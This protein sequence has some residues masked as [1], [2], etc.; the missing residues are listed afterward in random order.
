MPAFRQFA[1]NMSVGNDTDASL[2]H[3]GSLG[4]TIDPVGSPVG[5]G[6]IEF[7]SFAPAPS[8]AAS[9]GMPYYRLAYTG[10]AHTSAPASPARSLPASPSAERPARGRRFSNV[11]QLAD[12]SQFDLMD[13]SA[14][15]LGRGVSAVVEKMVRKMDGKVVA[16]KHIDAVGKQQKDAISRELFVAEER[17][18][19][20][21]SPTTMMSPRSGSDALF[22]VHH[23]GAFVT[24]HGAAIVMELMA[25]SFGGLPAMPEH[26][27]A[28]VAKMFLC[29]LRF[30]H[31]DL[32]VM[33]RD[34]KPSNLL[35]DAE[36]MLKITD[37]GLVTRLEHM[38]STTDKFAGSQLYMSPER[39][40]G[41]QYGFAG[42]VFS[43]GVT[44]AQLL[45]GQHPL[46]ASL[47]RAMHGA[48]EDRFWALAE[49]LGFNDGLA[50]SAAA[51]ERS[52][53][54]ALAGRCS[55]A[56]LEVV[57]R[58]VH[59]DPGKRPTC[60]ALLELPVID[61]DGGSPAESVLRWLYDV[62]PPS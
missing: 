50:A 4:T 7:D 10:S 36:G 44:V 19:C 49:A 23:Y 24:P 47:G 28:P 51:T 39:L 25:G 14:S 16:V 46:A 38:D 27:V 31:E 12:Y 30:M 21:A 54:C 43:F 8:N 1:L 58:C 40:R 5:L 52:F 20:A 53:R 26:I 48:A 2:A 33:H 11:L 18:G 9:P 29:G 32:H 15:F 61:G 41:E 17:H 34:L 13:A 42:D 60:S 37:F 45:L 57:L 22:L 35:F 59:A 55:P 62:G 6:S 3:T 56:L